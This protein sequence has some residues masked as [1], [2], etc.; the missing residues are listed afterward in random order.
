MCSLISRPEDT[1]S[2]VVVDQLGLLRSGG[3]PL[4]HVHHCVWHFG[5]V[6]ALLLPAREL[7]G[8]HLSGLGNAPERKRVAVKQSVNGGSLTVRDQLSICVYLVMEVANLIGEHAVFV[9]QEAKTT[10]LLQQRL[11]AAIGDERLHVHLA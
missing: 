8:Q 11:S 4:Y 7:C 3:Q 9:S 6:T 2:V 10:L 5:D 1:H